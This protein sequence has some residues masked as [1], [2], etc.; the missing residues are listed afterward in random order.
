ME[1]ALEAIREG[2]SLRVAS[3]EYGIPRSTLGNYV[4]GKAILGA[5][6]GQDK[7]LTDV[8][9]DALLNFIGCSEVGYGKS[10]QEIGTYLDIQST[11]RYKQTL[12]QACVHV[13]THL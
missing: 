8:E 10:V 9:E 7:L 1:E 2:K 5:K 12:A 6:Q 13:Y 11:P 4:C 3:E